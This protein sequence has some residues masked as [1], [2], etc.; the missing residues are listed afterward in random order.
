MQVSISDYL[1]WK[2]CHYK[3]D[4]KR[5]LG[6]WVAP[7][8][9]LKLGTV[10]H[11]LFEHKLKGTT[12]TNLELAAMASGVSTA[13]RKYLA[14]MKQAIDEY[15]PEYTVLHTEH[16][17]SLGVHGHQLVGRLDAITVRDG[18]NWSTQ[19][20]TIRSGD[21]VA[22]ALHKVLWSPHEIVYAEMARSS[23]I[24]LAGT[25]IVLLKKLSAKAEKDGEPVLV[26]F[27]LERD[28]RLAT[29][30]LNDIMR[31]LYEMTSGFAVE[32]D[33]LACLGMFGN[34]PCPLLAHC[35]HGVPMGDLP[36]LSYTLENRYEDLEDD[37]S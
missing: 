22:H 21:T 17:L 28:E 7:S 12:A 18:Q 10:A 19:V 20:K 23:G 33:T 8:S 6:K 32:K 16:P 35:F 14:Y 2:D 13:D 31:G 9:V 3:Y 30:L 4:A 5:K 25:H 11:K 24:P 36:E 15:T 1:T 34:S 26:E 37:P 29:E 27:W